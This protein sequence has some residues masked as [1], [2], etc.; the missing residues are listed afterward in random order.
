MLVMFSWRVHIVWWWCIPAS[1]DRLVHPSFK[2][3][4]PNDFTRHFL[5]IYW[6]EPPSIVS[7]IP[8]NIVL[9]SHLFSNNIISNN[10][11]HSF[12]DDFLIEYPHVFFP[13]VFVLI[14]HVWR[15]PKNDQCGVEAALRQCLAAAAGAPALRGASHPKVP[16]AL[17]ALAKASVGHRGSTLERWTWWWMV[18]L[19][20]GK[21]TKNYGKS[22]FLMGK[23]TINGNL[24]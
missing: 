1:K 19:P 4:W 22:H 23:C 18:K 6:T 17:R 21:H 13:I 3:T 16:A 12:S 2:W 24:Q 20:S 7:Y 8:S 11:S 5:T 9:I 14:S 10:V 15:R